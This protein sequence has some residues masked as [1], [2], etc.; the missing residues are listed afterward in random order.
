MDCSGSDEYGVLLHE[1][2]KNNREVIRFTLNEYKGT[3]YIDVRT[4][5]KAEDGSYKPSRS[6]VTFRP[7]QFED[8]LEGTAA[9]GDALGVGIDLTE[10]VERPTSAVVSLP[11]TSNQ[12]ELES[13]R[14]A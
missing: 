12:D 2:E 9:V 1:F 6:G 14:H 4:F 10:I 5:Y 11:S 8:F 3:Q 7:E 13:G